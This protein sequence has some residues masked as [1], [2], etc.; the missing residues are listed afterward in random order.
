MG[1]NTWAVTAATNE[2]SAAKSLFKNF[3]FN[4]NLNFNPPPLPLANIALVKLG[5][6]LGRS[7]QFKLRF[8]F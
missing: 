4:S 3:N 5:L 8:K 1:V 7:N 2:H 6:T